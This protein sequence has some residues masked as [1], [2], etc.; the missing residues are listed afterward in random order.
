MSAVLTPAASV[1]PATSRKLKVTQA[2]V[3]VSEW[4]K[5]RSLRS[6]LWTLLAAVAPPD[7]STGLTG[8]ALAGDSRVRPP[9]RTLALSR[10]SLAG[11]RRA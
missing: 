8:S 7:V 3:V 2:R 1:A 10:A 5:F 6:T 11:N 9:A 4:T